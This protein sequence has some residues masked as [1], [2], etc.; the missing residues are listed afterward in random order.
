MDQHGFDLD[1][2]FARIGYPGPRAASLTLLRELVA[3]HSAA[4]ALRTSTRLRDAC[5]RWISLRYCY[6]QNTLFQGALLALGFQVTGLMARVR[7]GVP[8]HI[9]TP[10]SHMLL[11]VDLPEGPHLADVGYGALTPTAP[12]RLR[13]DLEQAT[14]NEVFRLGQIGDEFTLQ[15]EIAGGWEDI[16]RFGLLPQLPIDYEA[17]N[18]HTATRP[19][20]LFAA[21]L[22]V[23]RPT[24]GVRRTLF[25]RQFSVRRQG[26]AVERRVLR[27]RDDYQRVLAD[28]FGLMLSDPDLAVVM[29]L[30]AKYDPDW[31]DGGGFA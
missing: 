30:M 11:L 15:A 13:A 19:N 23:T 12:L 21:N 18:W 27:T 26:A 10:R 1:A 9:M 31:P 24:P 4:I 6:E 2:Y 20:A 16:Y 5:R 29:A 17:I 14:P 25:N 8:P 7:R 22:V 28:E 3:H